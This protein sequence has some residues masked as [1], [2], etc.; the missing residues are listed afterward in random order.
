METGKSIAGGTA[1]RILSA[2]LTDH[3][4]SICWQAW[5]GTCTESSFGHFPKKTALISKHGFRVQ[6]ITEQGKPKLCPLCGVPATPKHIVWLCKWHHGRGH[7]PMPPEWANRIAQHDEEPLW[8][9]GWIPLEPREQRQI[10]H[11]YQGHGNWQGLP[12]LQQHQSQGWAFTLDATPSTYD[13]RSQLW[14][15]GLCVHTLRTGQLH[16]LGAITAVPANPQTKAR[17]LVAGLAALAKHTSTEVKVIVQLATV[18]EVWSHPKH[19]LA[20]QDLLHELAKEDFQRVTVLYISRC[21]RTPHTPGS[22]PHFERRQRDAA[23][24]AWERASSLKDHKAAEWQ[25]VLDQDHEDIYRHAAARLAQVFADKQHYLHQKAPRHQA[26]HTKQRKKQL[27]NQCR[28]PWQAPYHRW[29]PHQSGYQCSACGERVHQAL[30]ASTIDDKLTQHCP[31]LLL[32]EEYPEHHS[33]HKPIQEKVTRAQV[34]ARLLE[35]QNAK[36]PESQHTLEETKGYLRCKTCGLN[37][38]KRANEGAFLGFAQGQCINQLYDQGHPGHASHT[39]WQAAMPDLWHPH[40]ARCPAPTHPHGSF[41]EDLQGSPNWRLTANY[42]SL[43][44]TNSQG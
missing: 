4:T 23:L 30:T 11:P 32:E 5:T 43:S 35:N 27:V 2:W 1:Q 37:V 38:H 3:T 34:I 40:P 7:K 19:R 22:E 36:Q 15:F 21:T 26:R 42:R 33:P 10:L 18:W 28:K 9:A 14:V 17:A 41:A 12:V 24:T 44:E 25:T 20:Y 13:S 16:R 39:L 6:S 31:Q 8:S 29:Q